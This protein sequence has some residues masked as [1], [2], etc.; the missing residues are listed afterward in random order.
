MVDRKDPKHPINGACMDGKVMS[1]EWVPVSTG[2]ESDTQLKVT[3]VCM[4]CH[5]YTKADFDYVGFV[6]GDPERWREAI[7]YPDPDEVQ[8]IG[9]AEQTIFEGSYV[10]VPCDD[11]VYKVTDLY[12][13]D[14][15]T[16]YAAVVNRQT[17]TANVY[18]LYS[19]TLVE[20][21]IEQGDCVKFK[22]PDYLTTFFV[23]RIT[24]INKTLSATLKTSDGI[25]Y[26]C[27][28]ISDLELVSK[29]VAPE[30]PIKVG[31]VVCLDNNKDKIYHV[32]EICTDLD[33]RAAI[34]SNGLFYTKVRQDRLT[35]VAHQ[36][37]E[38]Y[39]GCCVDVPP[40]GQSDTFLVKD[41]YIT[42]GGDLMYRVIGVNGSLYAY[43]SENLGLRG[44]PER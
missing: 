40:T 39:V 30:E 35:V 42:R 24:T 37:D 44:R 9:V 34:Y 10:T 22:G 32:R 43:P 4:K 1:H 28:P 41:H 15:L 19:L 18:P 25:L 36:E 5:G 11:T 29:Y 17:K 27:V 2:Y 31:D 14:G 38:I 21:R 3:I 13:A 7:G 8:R 26:G 16:T 33:N 12:K 23:S 6:M 20:P